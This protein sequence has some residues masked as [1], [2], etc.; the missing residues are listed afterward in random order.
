MI[1]FH[2]LLLR[3]Q[4][5]SPNKGASHSGVAGDVILSHPDQICFVLFSPC[6]LKFTDG[7]KSWGKYLVRQLTDWYWYSAQYNFSHKPLKF[8][9]YFVLLSKQ[10][11]SLWT[12]RENVKIRRQY[13][14]FQIYVSED[15]FI[16]FVI[17]FFSF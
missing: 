15:L 13:F 12:N 16:A 1:I 11:L 14:I 2:S 17:Y 3:N 6:E 5:L 4:R 9:S 7:S 10:Y 8:S